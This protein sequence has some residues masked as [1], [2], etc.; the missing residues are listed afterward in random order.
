MLGRIFKA[1]D[2][3]GTYPDLI[4]EHMAWQIGF[5][6]SKFL[7]AEA[8][9][10]GHTTP[11]M[12]NVI[13]GRDMR[14]SSPDL[15][16]ACMKGITAQ[17][18]DVIDVG[19]VDTPF[20]YFAINY[21][22]C[23]GGVATTASHNPPNY[24]GFKISRR[25][26]RPIG[27][28]SGLQD[29]RKF[30]AMVDPKG[31]HVQQGRIEKRDL[32]DAY[33]EHVLAFLDLSGL[34]SGKTIKV[35]IDASNAMAG[36][37]VPKV[38]GKKGE[39]IEGL[40][41][42]ELN[43][44]NR[45]GIFAHD[46]NPLVLSNLVQLQ[47]AVIEHKADLGICFDGDADRCMVIDERGAVV[48]CDHL[49]ALLARR[50]LAIDPGSPVVYDLRSSK[51]VPEEIEAAGGVPIRSRVGHV[52][53]KQAMGENAATFGGEV[54]GHFYFSD[55]FNTDSGAI[56]MATILTVRAATNKKISTLIRP[57]AR[58]V[59]S[60]ELN[61]E[62]EEPDEVIAALVEEYGTNAK[63]D[64]LD[65]IT[66]DAFSRRGWWFNVRKSNTEPLLRL[67]AEGRTEQQLSKLLDGL[68]PKLGVRVTH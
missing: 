15:A 13:I 53:M 50:F 55:N 21:L 67:N 44:E 19:L 28:M 30:A 64:K 42:I 41:I 22:D 49:T 59:Q 48:P 57:I 5:G 17:G 2:I 34:R 29:I 68:S 52:F 56:A 51:A 38:F 18:G 36:T 20:V 65:G 60:G 25:S 23:A 37:M 8:T 32:W 66:I 1:Y 7:R 63:V 27:E 40:E 3:R 61:F 4:N 16:A 47:A 39:D 14:L 6:A 10:E 62:C 35:V 24:N 33:R 46:P 45:K 9:A 31:N 11:M 58:Y 12:R 26:A 54:S 43:F